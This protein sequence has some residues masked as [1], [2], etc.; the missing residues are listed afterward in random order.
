MPY[1]S[2]KLNV[3][4]MPLLLIRSLE[5]VMYIVHITAYC[6]FYRVFYAGDPTVLYESRTHILKG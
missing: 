5:L 6:N 2:K 4:S 3:L 1:V